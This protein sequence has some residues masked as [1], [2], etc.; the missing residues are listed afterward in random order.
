MSLVHCEMITAITNDDSYTLMIRIF[1]AHQVLETALNLRQKL[2][3]SK[4]CKV[5]R[6]LRKFLH[7]AFF[8]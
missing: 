3:E 1:S 7:E 6:L 4:L 8:L 2:K 5:K